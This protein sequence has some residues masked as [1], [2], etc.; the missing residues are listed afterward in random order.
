MDSID[1]RQV[2]AY[3]PYLKKA[4]QEDLQKHFTGLAR[5]EAGHY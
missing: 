4:I 5:I 3:T 2:R 1:T